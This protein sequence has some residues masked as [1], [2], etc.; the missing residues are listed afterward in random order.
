MEFQ[1]WV[2]LWSHP[3]TLITYQKSTQDSLRTLS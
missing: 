3:L 1:L 2:E